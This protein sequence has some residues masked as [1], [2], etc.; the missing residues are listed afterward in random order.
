MGQWHRSA[1][2]G[3][4]RRPGV[5]TAFDRR[6][7]GSSDGRRADR[8]WIRLGPGPAQPASGDHLDRLGGQGPHPRR[9]AGLGLG[10]LPGAASSC[11]RRARDAAPATRA[12][13]GTTADT[14]HAHR[15]GAPAG[16]RDPAGHAAQGAATP[17]GSVAPGLRQRAQHPDPFLHRGVPPFHRHPALR[18][19]RDR[20]A[21]RRP[22]LRRCARA[23][24]HLRG[25]RL[26]LLALAP[27]AHRRPFLCRHRRPAGAP[28][29]RGRLCL[30]GTC[31]PRREPGP[32]PGTVGC[33]LRHPLRGAGAAAPPPPL[34]GPRSAGAGRGRG[35]RCGL[36]RA[37]RLAR[38]SPGPT[39]LHLSALGPPPWPPARVG[40]PLL[41]L[42]PLV[43]A[44][45]CTP[46]A[47]R[48]PPLREDAL[49]R[50]R[51]PPQSRPRL[52]AAPGAGRSDRVSL[53]RPCGASG[54]LDA[55]R[56]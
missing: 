47:W 50:H 34:R 29:Q 9:C 39:R 37:R 51:H 12:A 4:R 15:A 27:P 16:H 10:T 48:C 23:R 3:R 6:Y 7:G 56:L 21:Q 53:S 14:A 13:A 49:G 22:P 36:G 46:R 38:P 25:G 35:W 33:G 41:A 31:R 54:G 8:G 5:G 18:A 52:A 19:L 11:D 44:G 45:G 26:G 28:G 24:P 55:R 30:P 17:A 40:G 43:R 2:S 42:R 32:G 20:A 1:E